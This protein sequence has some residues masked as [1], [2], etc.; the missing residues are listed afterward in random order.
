[1]K[2]GKQRKGLQSRALAHL[3]QKF[4]LLIIDKLAIR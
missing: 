2:H 3:D 1:M 4:I